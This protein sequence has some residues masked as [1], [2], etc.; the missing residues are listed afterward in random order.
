MPHDADALGVQLCELRVQGSGQ[1]GRDVAV[2]FVVR[3]IRWLG[4]V[5]VEAGAGAEVPGVFFAGELQ[6]SCIRRS[7][8]EGLD[9]FCLLLLRVL[10]IASQWM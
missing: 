8:N 5:E 3:G 9:V 7:E 10:E 2:H 6:A 4:R 1:F